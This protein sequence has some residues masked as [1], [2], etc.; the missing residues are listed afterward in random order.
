MNIV[1]STAS[2]MAKISHKTL[3][4]ITGLTLALIVLIDVRKSSTLLNTRERRL[5][6]GYAADG[7]WIM[8]FPESGYVQLSKKIHALAGRAT[9]TNYGEV[10]L[11]AT[12]TLAKWEY[13]S[14][15]IWANHP[16]GP[17]RYRLMPMP[18]RYIPIITHCG[19]FCTECH[20]T[21]YMISK[22]KFADECHMGTKYTLPKT[23]GGSASLEVL[24]Y[25]PQ[26]IKK[27]LHLIRDPIDN[28]V[29]RFRQRRNL[30]MKDEDKAFL[31]LY[32]DNL[33]GFQAYCANQNV[34]HIVEDSVSWGVATFK[35]SYKVPCR[36]EFY[37]YIQWHNLAGEQAKNDMKNVPEVRVHVS[38]FDDDFDGTMTKVLNFF[39]MDLKEDLEEYPGKS[40]YQNDYSPYY[41]A[42]QRYHIACFL[43]KL[44]SPDMKAELAR[45]LDLCGEE[46][47]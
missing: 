34:Q 1:K 19:G 22:Y 17:F 18:E 8:A 23:E 10:V 16:N 11:E 43:K 41:S 13:D 26:I 40:L 24:T 2:K 38:D 42:S 21:K 32:P 4:T 29:D 20:S 33:Q 46:V 12:G 15:P 31:Q 9:G 27:T 30:A 47:M 37:R 36:A 7:A 25:D 6:E 28:I 45:Y 39:E 44:A 35:A 5:A 3:F 14:V